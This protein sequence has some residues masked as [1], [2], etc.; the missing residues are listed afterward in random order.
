MTWLKLFL[1]INI[2][3][4]GLSCGDGPKNEETVSGGPQWSNSV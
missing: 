1:L 3:K 4:Y 2:A